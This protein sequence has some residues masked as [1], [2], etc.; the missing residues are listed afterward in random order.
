MAAVK[1]ALNQSIIRLLTE[2][3]ESCVARCVA[4][5]ELEELDRLKEALALVLR[6]S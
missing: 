5:G 4:A 6:K 1:A 2:H 3:M